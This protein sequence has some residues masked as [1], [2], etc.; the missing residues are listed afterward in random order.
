MRA[1]LENYPRSRGLGSAY[2]YK[3]I[4]TYRADILPVLSRATDEAWL[5]YR[6]IAQL[7]NVKK[8]PWS[9][10]GK[11]CCMILGKYQTGKQ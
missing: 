8:I 7:K 1:I 6:F 11:T 3:K 4:P 10:A 5:N 2:I 9:P